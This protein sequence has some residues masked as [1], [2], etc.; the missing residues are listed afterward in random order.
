V[1]SSGPDRGDAAATRRHPRR[2]SEGKDS[3]ICRSVWPGAW[4]TRPI[5]AP[6]DEFGR[7]GTP[8][9]VFGAEVVVQLA[10]RASMVSWSSRPVR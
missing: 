8:A 2:V 7:E 4:V 6:R 5:E 9:F 10:W 3:S 1:T